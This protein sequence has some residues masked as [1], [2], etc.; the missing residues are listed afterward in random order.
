MYSLI[1]KQGIGKSQKIQGDAENN[2]ARTNKVKD[3]IPHVREPQQHSQGVVP[4]DAV[5]D[6]DKFDTQLLKGFP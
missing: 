6:N 4:G 5:G 2:E 1:P 3:Y